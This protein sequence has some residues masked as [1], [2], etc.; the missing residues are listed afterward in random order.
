MTTRTLKISESVSASTDVADTY[1][2]PDGQKIL[3]YNFMAEAS[4][5]QNS[6][7]C[8]VWDYGGTDEIL[9]STKGSLDYLP[10]PVEKTGDGSK[11]LAVELKNAE[12]GAL[13]LSGYCEFKDV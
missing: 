13:V 5:S 7:V 1:V 10:S 4:F 9:W 6:V 12:A 2:V 11:K 3:I 8:L